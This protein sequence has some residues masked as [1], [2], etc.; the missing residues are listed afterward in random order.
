[1]SGQPASDPITKP[2]W[3]S[4]RQLQARMDADIDR[5]YDEAKLDVK[6]ASQ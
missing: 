5:I 2:L 6:P 1:M 4:M 3:R